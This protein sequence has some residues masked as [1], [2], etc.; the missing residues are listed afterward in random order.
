MK[1]R[2]S[3]GM[4]IVL[5]TIFLVVGLLPSSQ[6]SSIT[7][8]ASRTSTH[9]PASTK[10]LP[11]FVPFPTHRPLSESPTL[12]PLQPT[13]TAIAAETSGVID[14]PTLLPDETQP[15]SV[16]T[17]TLI[18]FASATSTPFG[19]TATPPVPVVFTLDG[20]PRSCYKGPSLAYIELD[21][22]KIARIIGKDS[23][24]KWWYLSIN[25]GQ[26]VFVSCWVSGDQVITGGNLSGLSINEPELP[27]ITQVKV[28][29]SDQ[30]VKDAQSVQTIS[31]DAGLTMT[32]LHFTGHIF[33]NGPINDIG[34]LW[35][36]DAP[37]Q[38]Q[39]EHT[40]V[41]A[42]DAPAQIDVELPVPSQTGMYSLSLSTTFP[43]EIV[44]ELRFTVKC[45]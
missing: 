19:G 41:K 16:P 40:A 4:L 6:T 36:T 33:A 24:G 37:A 31:C 43:M 27:Q 38:F 3:F 39:V 25:K 23:T 12:I 45:K 15:Q 8:A 42:W 7:V 14:T 17:Q 29:I 22:F 21:T 20:K 10:T 9:T 35:T 11:P 2:F 32:T 26:N 13:Y 28:E 18:F 1:T 44:G 34:Y 5:L 30:S